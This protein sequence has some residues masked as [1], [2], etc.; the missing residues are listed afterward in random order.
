MDRVFKADLHVH[1][2]FSNQSSM[3]ALRKLKC[4]ESF[5]TPWTVYETAI[6][7][8]MDFVTITDHN[9]IDGALEIAH[10]P[11]VFI[12]S[13][14][15]TYFPENH[16][17]AH[18][19]VLDV[20][21]A[22]FE[23]ARRLRK[24][25][26]EFTGYLRQEGI[27][28]FLAHPLYDLN[29]RLDVAIVE[30][31]LLLFNVF[32]IRNGT[33]HP[34][35]ARMMGGILSRLDREGIERLADNH[36]IEPWGR[37]PWHK[38]LVGGSDDHSGFF[39]ARTWTESDSGV[40]RSEFVRSVAEFRTR[41]GGDHGGSLTLA[42]SIYGIGYRFVMEKMGEKTNRSYPILRTIADW[43]LNDP[44]KPPTRR[45]R[46][47]QFL[48][49]TFRRNSYDMETASF[50]RILDTEA[51]SL[52]KDRLFA[53]RL[54]E[55]GINRRIFRITS[56]LAN[57][58]LYVYTHRL[59]RT[60]D[61]TELFG[62]FNAVSSIG[63][64]HLMVTPYYLSFHSQN[65]SKRLLDMLSEAF[66]GHQRS[67]G[68]P[69]IAL[70]TDTLDEINGVAITIRRMLETSRRKGIDFTV[71]TCAP[72][73]TGFRDGVMNFQ[74][75]GEL[76]LPE[77]PEL[78]VCFPPVLD[79]IDYVE[80]QGF[81]RL[82]ISTPGSVGLLGLLISRL[83]DINADG[84]Y[85]TEIPMYVR[86]LTND[87]FL[88]NTAWQYMV[89]FYNLMDE[90]MV[91]SASTRQ[92]L[93]EHGLEEGKVKPLP[94][95]VDTTE[96][97]PAHRDPGIWREM[98]FEA[99]IRFLYV[100]RVSKEKNLELLSD[101]FLLMARHHT[102]AG[103]VVVGDGPYRTEMEK[104]LHGSNCLFTGFRTGQE[105]CRLYASSDVFVF[106]STTDTFGNVVLEAQASGLPVI[107]TDRGGPH[108]LIL[109]GTTG[110]VLT[111]IT[112]RTLA[113][114]LSS[115]AADLGLAEEMG[116]AAARFAVENDGAGD[117]EYEAILHC[118]PEPQALSV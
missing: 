39:I 16:V 17:K 79:V 37:E 33:R 66:L 116:S 10:L 73:P 71:I 44:E 19:V 114:Q 8:G 40:S 76:V 99:D 62:L 50:T 65:R 101:A 112:A 72:G 1:S 110:I 93:L 104:R 13:E 55:E 103:L 117:Q 115:F 31:M 2:S 107:V 64:A 14:I 45:E 53:E 32:E 94:R 108:E 75:I 47:R 70:F 113:H 43:I 77:Y 97:T 48:V 28:H 52:M 67:E 78:K 82:H 12:S 3:W 57:R 46:F 86:E 27:A 18:V 49:H 34:R 56:A 30:K 60:Q 22:Q 91:P 38:G 92:Q 59:T 42:H 63:L 68:P 98:N 111:G 96:F 95:W 74:P 106:P 105:L 83:M 15:T 87:D 100:G 51:R 90:V 84:T 85:H 54:N 61:L 4:P 58:L 20:S 88:E 102:G 6:R 89:W 24:N 11:E 35:F 5:T 69:K 41:P 21:P 109:D 36:D 23:E 26:Y 25:I 7:R 9:S 29:S 118:A 80:R 81:T